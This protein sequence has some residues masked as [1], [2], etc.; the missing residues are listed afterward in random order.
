MERN[1]IIFVLY[2]DLRVTILGKLRQ[3]NKWETKHTNLILTKTVKLTKYKQMLF[4][5]L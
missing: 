3:V 2:C 1:Y 5:Q 4:L